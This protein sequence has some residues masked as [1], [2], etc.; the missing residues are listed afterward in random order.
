MP[1][2]YFGLE[3]AEQRGIKQGMQ[4][5]MQQN[6]AKVAARMLAKGKSDAE[7]CELLQLK[8]KELAKLKKEL[9]F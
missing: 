5:G 1:T 2:I 8:K 6:Q 3:R 9:D 4:Q 7:I